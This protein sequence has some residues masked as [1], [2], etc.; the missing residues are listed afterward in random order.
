MEML[1]VL[2]PVKGNGGEKEDVKDKCLALKEREEERR[3]T[4]THKEQLGKIG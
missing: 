1:D 3:K 4:R 2:E